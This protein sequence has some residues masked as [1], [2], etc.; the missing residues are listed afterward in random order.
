MKKAG[1]WEGMWVTLK[2]FQS[3]QT[4]LVIPLRR[5]TE[6]NPTKTNMRFLTPFEMTSLLAMKDL[7]GMKRVLER[8]N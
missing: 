3:F 8:P 7:Q 4:N 2:T 5:L 6:R 1:K